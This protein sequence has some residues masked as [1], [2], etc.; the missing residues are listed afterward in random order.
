MGVLIIMDEFKVVGIA[1]VDF[2]S[3]D[4]DD[5]IEGTNLYVTSSDLK[6]DGLKAEKFF[7]KK[8][9]LLPDGLKVG[10]KISLVYNRY[11]KVA[12]VSLV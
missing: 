10:A 11:G 4:S 12:G 9:I 2:K 8:D 7:L 1:K 5:K 6:V 3:K